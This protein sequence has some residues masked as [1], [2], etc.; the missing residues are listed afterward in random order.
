MKKTNATPRLEAL[1]RRLAAFKLCPAN[2]ANRDDCACAGAVRFISAGRL[3]TDE[4]KRSG[5]T[6]M[7]QYQT[8]M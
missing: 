4:L 2:R 5:R 3:M 6:I 1:W 7:R 8:F